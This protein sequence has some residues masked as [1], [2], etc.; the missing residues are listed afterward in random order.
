[1]DRTIWV[2]LRAVVRGLDDRPRDGRLTFSDADIVLTLLWAVLHGRAVSWACRRE[3]WPIFEMHVRRPS[4]ARMSRRLRSPEVMGLIEK[5]RAAL[6]HDPAG[7]LA[8]AVDGK[9]MRVARHSRD[10]SATF[11]GFGLRGYK[12]H[13]IC[14]L[15]GRIV[16]FRVTP[17]HCHEAVMARR[18][19]RPLRID[20]YLLA[21]TNY[22]SVALHKQCAAKGGQLV[23]PRMPSR[24]SKP[25]GRRYN[26]PARQR[27]VNMLECDLTGFGPT[28]LAQRDVIERVFGRLEMR[29]RIGTPPPNIRGLRRVRTWIAAIV[30]LELGRT[31]LLSNPRIAA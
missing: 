22:D 25:P 30:I 7:Q 24:R 17:L 2:K 20:G 10:R 27:A 6:T 16:G 14:D 1:M 13:L 9:V 12:L 23:A 8:L 5:V 3:A 29:Y 18:M 19:I 31:S 28:L 4:P 21:D 11:G 26:L 15:E